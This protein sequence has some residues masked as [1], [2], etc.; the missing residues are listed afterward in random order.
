MKKAQVAEQ[1]AL[2]KK[3]LTQQQTLKNTSQKYRLL[4][5]RN[6]SLEREIAAVLQVR[7][8]PHAFAIKP[9][10]QSKG[11]ESTAVIVAS[12]WHLEEEVR[13]GSVN[14]LNEY[15]LDTFSARSVWLFSALTPSH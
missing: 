8:G 5:N 13:S 2:D 1:V 11:S 9:G 3:L 15:T 10:K 4:L 12:D 14:G 6:D 7:K